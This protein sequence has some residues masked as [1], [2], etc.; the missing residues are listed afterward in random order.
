[1]VLGVTHFALCVW[2]A[3]YGKRCRIQ[4]LDEAAS[5]QQACE[6]AELRLRIHP[7]RYSGC[8]DATWIVDA[9]PFLGAIV[10]GLQEEEGRRA[11]W[12]AL[13]GAPVCAGLMVR[14][15]WAGIAAFAH[16]LLSSST[17]MWLGGDLVLFPVHAAVLGVF[18]AIDVTAVVWSIGRRVPESRAPLSAYQ[19][20]A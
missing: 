20:R 14:R 8:G 17:L 16:V 1:M 6:K 13:L 18:L 9:V 11:L 10:N 3:D 7:P 2:C 15:R 4:A 19:Q 5:W 12:L